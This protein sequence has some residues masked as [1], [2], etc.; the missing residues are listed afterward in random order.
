MLR[1][2]TPILNLLINLISCCRSLHLGRSCAKAF[3]DVPS[4]LFLFV[5]DV[6]IAVRLQ[7]AF[8]QRSVVQSYRVAG[9]SYPYSLHVLFNTSSLVTLS[10]QNL[11]Q[12]PVTLNVECFYLPFLFFNYRTRFTC[13]LMLSD[14]IAVLMFNS[15][16]LSIKCFFVCVI[17]LH[18]A[19]AAI[20]YPNGR[21]H[22][23]IL[24][25]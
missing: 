21:T 3:V 4:Y 16:F 11:H 1:T 2:L 9:T 5:Q 6:C 25:A 15:C 22:R 19:F 20:S 7:L 23:P 18:V 12:S 8:L 24:S 17:L 13:L 14:S 10:T